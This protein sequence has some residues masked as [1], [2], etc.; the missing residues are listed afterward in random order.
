MA[1]VLRCVA[2]FVA[3]IIVAFV[4]VIAVEFFSAVV[5]PMP[6]DFKGTMEEM[7][8]HVARY[9]QWVLAVVVPAWAFT[10]FAGTW[11][12]GRIGNRTSALGVGLLL[13]VGVV[14]NVSKLPYPLW[15]K[16]VILLVVPVAIALGDRWSIRRAPL[17]AE[18]RH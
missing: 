16:L 17:A 7:C 11:V 2:A 1:Q 18:Q 5:H 14:C 13:V 12:A 6:P 8:Q 4:F 3:G 15:F 10:A 9:P